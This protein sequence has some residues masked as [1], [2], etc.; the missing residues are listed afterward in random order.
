MSKKDF[1]R[2]KYD[3]RGIEITFPIWTYQEDLRL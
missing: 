1:V 2:P 3:D